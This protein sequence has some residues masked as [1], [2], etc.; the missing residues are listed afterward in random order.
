MSIT[1]DE[2]LNDVSMVAVNIPDFIALRYISE[3]IDQ[4]CSRTGAIE[5]PCELDLSAGEYEADIATDSNIETAFYV[6]EIRLPTGTIISEAGALNKTGSGMPSKY[7]L[8]DGLV[9]FNKTP[10]TNIT[11]T[12]IALMKPK[13]GATLF[14]DLIA[15]KYRDAIVAGA[16]S[17]ALMT[18]ASGGAW[19]DAQL[20]SYYRTVFNDELRIAKA[21]VLSRSN[22]FLNPLRFI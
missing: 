4:F 13:R 11:L 21:E 18:K 22:Q 9:Y 8:G 15:T 17:R 20:G 6:R 7:K 5:L 19:F 16:L 2:F 12:G 10:A 14:N 3:A 1:A